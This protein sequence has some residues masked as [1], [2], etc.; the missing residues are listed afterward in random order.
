MQ[1]LFSFFTILLTLVLFST[2]IMAQT[3]PPGSPDLSRRALH[4][5]DR[6]LR[7]QD[8]QECITQ[9]TQQT[10]EKR[11]RSEFVLKCMGD[12]QNARKAATKR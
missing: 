9:A 8:R 2:D 3:A 4:Q 12:R 1:C 10:I 7:L 11:N 5:Q 6:Q